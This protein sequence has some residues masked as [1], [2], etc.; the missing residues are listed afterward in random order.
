MRVGRVA[1]RAPTLRIQWR[2]L[3]K[4]GAHGARPTW[5]F[6]SRNHPGPSV[7]K[8]TS[9]PGRTRWCGYGQ[10]LGRGDLFGRR[11][12]SFRFVRGFGAFG[13]FGQSDG[14][15]FVAVV[16]VL[17]DDLLFGAEDGVVKRPLRRHAGVARRL[18]VGLRLREDVRGR[19]QVAGGGREF[20][21]RERGKSRFGMVADK[22]FPQLGVGD[23]GHS[24]VIC[25]PVGKGDE[26]FRRDSH[27]G[28]AWHPHWSAAVLK[29]SRSH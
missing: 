2:L 21:Q 5:L 8:Q 16:A 19:L 7:A 17:R 3:A 20:G 25:A 4:S 11:G 13:F 26:K 6:F 18:P 23:F 27:Q 10:E 14:L 29:A 15:G 12:F 22:L 1:P 9:A 24:P 28:A